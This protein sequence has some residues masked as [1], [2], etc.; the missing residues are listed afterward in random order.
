MSS[1]NNLPV[2]R[3]RIARNLR[4]WRATRGMSQDKLSEL[5]GFTQAYISQIENGT[6]NIRID[7]MEKLAEVLGIDLVELLVR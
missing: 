6:C 5:S 7:S 3:A 1:Q 2:G 4:D